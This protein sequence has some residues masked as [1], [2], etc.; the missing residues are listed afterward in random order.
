MLAKFEWLNFEV[1]HVSTLKLLK[2]TNTL[3]YCVVLSTEE[4]K[5]FIGLVARKTFFP[6]FVNISGLINGLRMDTVGQRY[7]TFRVVTDNSTM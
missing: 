6:I 5:S 1:L 3:A 7:K 2:W 4:I